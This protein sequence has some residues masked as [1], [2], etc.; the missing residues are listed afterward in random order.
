I[1]F[2]DAAFSR[3]VYVYGLQQNSETRSNLA[4]VNLGF[5]YASVW[6]DG[7]AD[8]FKIEIF[9]GVTG[10]KV[11]TLDDFVVDPKRWKQIDRVLEQYATGTQQAYIRITRT[12]GSNP[13]F[14]YGVLNDGSRPGERTGD[15]A[16]VQGIYD[17]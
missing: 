8:Y 14:V 12:R 10:E 4:I 7:S 3:P 1:P 9:D 15:G 11:A 16:F 17:Y 6:E 2:R 5:V 13:F